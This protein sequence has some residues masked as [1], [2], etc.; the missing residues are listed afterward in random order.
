MTCA[1][2]LFSMYAVTWLALLAATFSRVLWFQGYSSRYYRKFGYKCGY[3]LPLFGQI[4]KSLIHPTL[5]C[6]K[7]NIL[8]N[9]I[10]RIFTIV[11]KRP[12]FSNVCLLGFVY[13]LTYFIIFIFIKEGDTIYYIYTTRYWHVYFKSPISGDIQQLY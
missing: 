9:N 11:H 10:K 12:M 4:N 8:Q 2:M 1:R 5:Y 3:W 7:M 13:N 6:R